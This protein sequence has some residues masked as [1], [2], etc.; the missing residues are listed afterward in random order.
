MKGFTAVTKPLLR[1]TDRSRRSIF[2]ILFVMIG[3]PAQADCVVLLHGLARGPASLSRLQSG[4]QDAGYQV[5]NQGYPSRSAPVNELV[6]FVGQGIAECPA[7]QTV[8]IVGY[9]LGGILAQ[10]WL[11]NHQ[12]DNLGRVVMLAPPNA[13]SLLVDKLGG[14]PGF[15]LFSGPAGRRLGTGM[16]S[17]PLS[18]GPV[19]F[20]LG[21]IAGDASA[22]PIT[23]AMTPGPDDG[24]VAV[25]ATR[26]GGIADHITLPVTHTFMM[27]N[28]AVIAKVIGFLRDGYFRR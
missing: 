27:N 10:I 5:V 21:V 28:P 22:N 18:L 2:A 6:R 14:L 11:S 8:H 26:L 24:K 19:D 16:A 7:D 9:S 1:R 23:S 17:V 3:L 25:A 12:P 4:L 13:G 20:P 15:V